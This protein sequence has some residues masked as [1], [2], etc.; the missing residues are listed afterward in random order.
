MERNIGNICQNDEASFI[1]S[2]LEAICRFGLKNAI[3]EKIERNA[4]G[5]VIIF[6]MRDYSILQKTVIVAFS[7]NVKLFPRLC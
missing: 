6:E 1:P 4:L 7:G 3:G 5:G 2:A